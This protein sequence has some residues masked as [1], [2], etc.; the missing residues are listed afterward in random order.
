MPADREI[1][2]GKK[3]IFAFGT[4]SAYLTLSRRLSDTLMVLRAKSI[5]FG[6]ELPH[7]E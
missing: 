4:T 2:L 6:S 3:F 5:L 1:G 7:R